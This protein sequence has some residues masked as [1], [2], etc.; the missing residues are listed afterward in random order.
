[1]MLNPQPS[2]T[3]LAEIYGEQYALLNQNDRDREHFA[4]LKK[5]TARYYLDLIS[6]YRGGPGGRLLE[7]GSGHGDLLAVAAD[8]GYDVTGVEYSEHAC[9]EARQRL[10][11]RGTVI[12]G[13]LSDVDGEAA[14]DVCVL[15]DLIEH[16]RNPRVFLTDVHKLLRPGGTLFVA[17]PSLDSWSAK[18]LKNNWMEFKAEHL[19]YFNRNSLHNLLFQ[20]G[21]QQV[22]GL[23]GVK[24]LTFDYIADHFRKYPVAKVSAFVKIASDCLPAA[25][26]RK[27]L[28]V[29]ASGMISI[30][31]AEPAPNRWKVSIIVPAYNEVATVDTVIRKLLDKDLDPLEKEIVIVE[32]NSS[33]GTR[34]RVLAYGSHPSVKVVLEDRPR[35]KGHA[36]RTG[37]AHATGDF[38]LIQDADLE[39]DFEDYEVLLEPLLNGRAAF[40]LGS[41][42]GG[43]SW[44]MRSFKG[45]RHLSSF[46]NFGH[47][48]FR[49]LI[50]VLFGL[51]LKDPFTMFKVFRRDCLTG[52]RFECNYFDFDYEL[53]IKLVRNGYT[54]VEIPVNYRSRSFSE[55]KKVSII[56]DPITWFRVLIRLRF[57]KPDPLIR[58]RLGGPEA[59]SEAQRT[60]SVA[61]R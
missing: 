60:E 31:S 54:P 7:I 3:D 20:T 37:L 47:W 22:V 49:S 58:V 25:L 59:A 27:K 28:R 40:V 4:F 51:S 39:Y 29:V 36:V 38:L 41:R 12:C 1:M 14:F 16:V 35:G 2:D 15:S 48:F 33:D 23:P 52:L 6:R 61:V 53:L 46:L 57:S 17:T 45:S 5:A 21:F 19:H 8:C 30:C 24:I 18:I 32:S 56:R 42:H 43:R 50:N 44:K 34:E 9:N 55:G 11:G 10:E 13:E 26:R